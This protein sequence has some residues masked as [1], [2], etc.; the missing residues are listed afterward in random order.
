MEPN[1]ER[2]IK[3]VRNILARADADRN[4]NEH[5]RA[6]ALRQ[7]HALL[8]KHGLDMADVAGGVENAFGPLGKVRV[9]DCKSDWGWTAYTA[10]G[11]LYGCEVTRGTTGRRVYGLTLWGRRERLRVAK[12]MAAYVVG[13]IKR[14][15]A[16][17]YDRVEWQTEGLRAWNNSFGAGA[18]LGLASQIARILDAQAA[19]NVGDEHLTPGQALVV[20]SQHK[21][22]LAESAALAD[23]E[24]APVTK[25]ARDLKITDA[26]VLGYRYG[27]TLSL[28]TQLEGRPAKRLGATR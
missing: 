13:S 26:T 12:S 22:A 28:N 15:S 5:E 23:A 6:I 9:E 4:D 8:A 11:A 27:N 7:A 1:I 21:Q 18:A 14:E 24:I 2:I 20:V 25:P 10:V 17:A 16:L 3:K 19:G